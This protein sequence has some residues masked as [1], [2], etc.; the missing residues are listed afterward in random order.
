MQQNYKEIRLSSI[1]ELMTTG[2]LLTIY[3]VSAYQYLVE[4]VKMDATA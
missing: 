3:E 2:Y 4:E 1:S